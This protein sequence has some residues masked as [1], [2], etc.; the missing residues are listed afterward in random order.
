MFE[1][2]YHT[3]YQCPNGVIPGVTNSLNSI[4]TAFCIM[5]EGKILKKAIDIHET[6]LKN[7][8]IL[9]IEVYRS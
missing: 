4:D 6:G 7:I 8:G 1:K 9:Y 5:R 3:T 2:Y